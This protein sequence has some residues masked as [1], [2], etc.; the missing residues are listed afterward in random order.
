MLTAIGM[1]SP[2]TCPEEQPA[3][4]APQLVL[5]KVCAN[6]DDRSPSRQRIVRR[7][8]WFCCRALLQGIAI[9]VLYVPVDTGMHTPSVNLASCLSL[10]R[11]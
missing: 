10:F 3:I 9:R 2:E 7:R 5:W 6:V 4:I 1:I 8:E 11:R